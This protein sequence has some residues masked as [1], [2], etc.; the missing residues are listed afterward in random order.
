MRL[1]YRARAAHETG[2]DDDA[3]EAIARALGI[4][5]A[6]PYVRQSAALLA[7]DEG[8]PDDA[9]AHLVRAR[10]ASPS[11]VL[12]PA[13]HGLALF[14]A[15]DRAAGIELLGETL[16]PVPPALQSRVA[17][18]LE[19]WLG[20][21]SASFDRCVLELHEEPEPAAFAA[22]NRY[23]VMPEDLA[24]WIHVRLFDRERRADHAAIR[25]A[26]ELVTRGD[27]AG[28]V[29]LLAG[30]GSSEAVRLALAEAYLAAGRAEEA[31]VKLEEVA[32]SGEQDPFVTAFRAA[33]LFRLGRSAECLALLRSVLE[34]PSGEGRLLGDDFSVRYLE[35]LSLL[36]TGEARAARRTFERAFTLECPF[37]GKVLVEACRA[38][39]ALAPPVQSGP[40]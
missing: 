34:A 40:S 19:G 18:H 7:L 26:G 16:L 6:D 12:L 10:E 28:A 24:E 20:P 15:G 3:G 11:N 4:S 8:R 33:A 22:I 9:L 13:Y 5:G 25:R 14:L 30:A 1:C 27:P 2:R 23:L 17:L 35:G 37:A 21:G 36:A 31:L 38:R 39:L 32:Q 29:L